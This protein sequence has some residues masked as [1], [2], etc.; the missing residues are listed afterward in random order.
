M[1]LIPPLVILLTLVRTLPRSTI[2]SMPT[3]MVDPELSSS[4]ARTVDVTDAELIQR[5]EERYN[6]E[7]LLVAARTLRQVKR[8][9]QHLN[10]RH[11]KM[12]SIADMLEDAVED[13]LAPPRRDWKKQG[14]THG[15][16]ET[17][18]YYKIESGGRLTCRIETPIPKDMMVPILSVLNESGLYRTWIPSWTRPF[19]LGVR[20][21]KQLVNDRRGH[22]VIQIKS[23]VPWPMAM[24]DT[25][26]D[27]IAVDDIDENGCIIVKMQT[28]GGKNE[29]SHLLP[30]G[31]ELPE[32]EKGSERLD[33][34]GSILFRACPTDHPTYEISR[35]KHPSGDLV[36]LQYNM[37]FDARMPGV[38]HSMINFITRV[39]IGMIWSMLLKVAE[40]VKNG[41][42]TE[43]VEVIRQ[44]AGFYKWLEDR[45]QLM[46]DSKSKDHTSSK[47]TLE[48]ASQKVENDWTMQDALRLA[49]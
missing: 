38:P 32:L 27:V 29:G 26:M 48:R 42:R 9:E 6:A 18:I 43:H 41:K 37:H 45:C 21:S 46:L 24:R 34:D 40:E 12:L 16:Y 2:S 5:A 3:T 15:A 39:V 20:E 4:P 10:E 17:S 47:V 35:R 44:K 22:Q 14:E 7:Q 31:F 1:M 23:D 30:D 28:L 49:I 25:V 11:L 33:F 36:L 13:F 8:P 19:R